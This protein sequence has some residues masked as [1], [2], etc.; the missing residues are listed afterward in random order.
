[1]TLEL[2]PLT[3]PIKRSVTI[4]GHA[5]SISLEDAF[6]RGA[7]R[8]AASR[9][10]TRAALIAAID[11]ARPPQVGLATAVRLFVLDK[12][13]RHSGQEAATGED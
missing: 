5:T 6:W 12:A 9:N 10:M 13:Q 3:P 4:D 7:G 8:V 11:R 2:P 1:M